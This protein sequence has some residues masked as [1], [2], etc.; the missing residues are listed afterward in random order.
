MLEEVDT[1]GKERDEQMFE[2]VNRLLQNTTHTQ[3]LTEEEQGD[4]G[5]LN[6]IT[7]TTESMRVS[8]HI[9]PEDVSHGNLSGLAVITTSPL[10]NLN[11]TSRAWVRAD[12]PEVFSVGVEIPHCPSL[13]RLVLLHLVEVELEG[14]LLL[15]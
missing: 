15:L 13:L 9:Q 14:L 4:R 6:N 7:Q 12:K 3:T 1:K 11:T 10:S 5:A 8:P 2:G